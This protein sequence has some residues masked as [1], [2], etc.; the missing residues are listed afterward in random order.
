MLPVTRL[1]LRRLATDTLDYGKPI[2]Y[3]EAVA[4]AVD[5]L[6]DNIIS[7][8]RCGQMWYTEEVRVGVMRGGVTPFIIQGVMKRLH[9]IFPDVTVQY[10]YQANTNHLQ[11]FLK[12]SWS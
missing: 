4:A 8:A 9:E 3:D 11:R 5:R 7:A 2:P 10:V 1:T 12:I 6:Y